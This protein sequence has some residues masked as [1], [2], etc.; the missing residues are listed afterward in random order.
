ML[1]LLSQDETKKVW[2]LNGKE[3]TVWNDRCLKCGRP[4]KSSFY[5]TG[6]RWHKC[7]SRERKVVLAIYAGGKREQ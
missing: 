7:R 5:M 2:L 3:V 1:K 4:L 6:G